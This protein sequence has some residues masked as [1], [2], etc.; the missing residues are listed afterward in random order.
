MKNST[1]ISLYFFLKTLFKFLMKEVFL[2][3]HDKNLQEFLTEKIVAKKILFKQEKLM[4]I[5]F[6]T[7]EVL[8][9]FH[10]QILLQFLLQFF[11]NQCRLLSYNRC[12]FLN[13]LPKNF[14]CEMIFF[15]KKSYFFKVFLPFHFY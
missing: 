8:H 1:Y 13:F 10:D 9:V 7:K 11:P 5:F 12:T 3:F 4:K 14:F 2:I 15:Q 6:M